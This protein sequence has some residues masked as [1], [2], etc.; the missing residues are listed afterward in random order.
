VIAHRLATIRNADRIIVLQDGQVV[1]AGS[2][3]ELIRQ[4]GLYARLYRLN[5][6]SFDDASE[7]LLPS[8]AGVPR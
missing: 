8:P 4:R 7:A 5:Y 3:R 2:H 6:A 1:E